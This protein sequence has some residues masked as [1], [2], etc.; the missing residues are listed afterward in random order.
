VIHQPKINFYKV[1]VM[2]AVN[3][4]SDFLGI[5]LTKNV[6]GVAFSTVLPLLTGICIGYWALNKYK[7]FSF[8]NIFKVGYIENLSLIKQ[9]RGKHNL[10]V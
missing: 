4:G 2:L 10:Q 1:L 3:V 7:R 9:L 5:Y 8:W 6:Y